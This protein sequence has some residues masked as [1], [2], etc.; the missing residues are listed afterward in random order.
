MAARSL[1]P[2]RGSRGISDFYV[3]SIQPWN[4]LSP[5]PLALLWAT[6][7]IFSLPLAFFRTNQTNCDKMLVISGKTIKFLRLHLR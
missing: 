6:D 5:S 7:S 2:A 3:S 4:P 1:P